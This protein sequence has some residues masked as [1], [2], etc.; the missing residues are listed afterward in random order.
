MTGRRVGDREIIALFPL[1][2]VLVP[3]L[4]MPLHIFEPRY[5]QLIQDQEDQPAATRGFGIIAIRSGHEVGVDGVRALHSIGTFASLIEVDPYSDGRADILTNGS[6]RFRLLGLVDSTTPYL[7]AEV[8]WLDEPEGGPEA[9]LLS[10]SVGARFDEYRAHIA[11]AGWI[12]EEDS[13]RLPDEPSVRSYLI[14]AA[15][16]LDLTDHQRL[17][18]APSTVDR[19]LAELV[20]LQ[21]EI[22][23]LRE[24]PS[25][26]AT[27]LTR[28]PIALN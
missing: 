15:M 7:R 12:D 20:L 19:L 22:T 14:A 4:V 24:L 8:E 27:E 2:S 16:I 6:A 10:I 11:G 28:V 25:L 26:P 18:E 1:G 17:L 21:R 23:L 9:E 13:T 5:R 3:G